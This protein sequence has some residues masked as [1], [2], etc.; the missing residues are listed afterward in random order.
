MSIHYTLALDLQIAR[1]V[2]LHQI[3]TPA[4]TVLASARQITDL[5]ERLAE[6]TADGHIVKT[7]DGQ[8]QITVHRLPP[9]NDN[10]G[11]TIHGQ[12]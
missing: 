11:A 10:E 7:D 2:R 3:I 6:L 1:R 9:A 5:L 4:E 8:F 12:S